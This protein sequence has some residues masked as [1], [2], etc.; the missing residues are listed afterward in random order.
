MRL[1]RLGLLFALAGC[2]SGALAPPVPADLSG[3][4][5]VRHDV[6]AGVRGGHLYVAVTTATHYP[7]IERFRIVHGLPDSTPDRVYEG[8]GGLIAVGGDGTLY[9]FGGVSSGGDIYAFG[10]RGTKPVRKLEIPSPG[11]CGVSSSEETEISALAAD[12]QGYLFAAIY[13]S[14]GALAPRTHGTVPAK[15][16]GVPCNG[17]AVFAPDANGKVSPVQTVPLGRRAIITGI[18]VDPRDNLYITEVP[19]TV[20]QF[21]NAITDPRRTRV[22]HLKP[23]AHVSSIATD[24]AGDVFISN[25]N[26]GYKTGWIDRY[27]PSA[28]PK[29]PPTSEITFQGS[30]LHFLLSIAVGRRVLYDVDDFD[31]VDLYHALQNRSQS[32]FYSFAASDVSA[33]AIGP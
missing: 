1:A 7:S 14:A 3:A 31:S 4:A 10:P 13:T 9:A 16:G 29:G 32:P 21:T 17:V 26:Y 5:A 24:D 28:K 19:Y 11:R 22:F 20:A 6:T 15:S 2:Q 23:P 12:A 8:Y 33:V 18:A 30:N 27:S 25:V